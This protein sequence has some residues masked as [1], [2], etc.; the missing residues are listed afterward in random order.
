VAP[1]LKVDDALILDNSLLNK[2]E[3]LDWILDKINELN[4]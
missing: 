4:S 1:L 3:Q 2:E